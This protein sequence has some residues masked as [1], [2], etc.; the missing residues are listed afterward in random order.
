VVTNV[1]DD[2]MT[3][4]PPENVMV[5]LDEQNLTYACR[6]YSE[7]VG[8]KFWYEDSQLVTMLSKL[9]PNRRIAQVRCY[10]ALAAVDT[11][12]PNDEFRYQSQLNHFLDLQTNRKWYVFW[13]EVKSYDQ[14]CP[15]CRKK[16]GKSVPLICKTCNSQVRIPKN[17]GVDVALATDL[18]FY[19]LHY[20]FPYD[21]ATIVSGDSDFLPVVDRLK[22]ERPSVRIEFVQ[23]KRSVGDKIKQSPNAS[24]YDL[25]SRTNLFGHF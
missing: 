20:K 22:Q 25:D 9:R 23:F 18:L 5:F 3:I 14:M 1:C 10:S 4:S 6:D 15:N 12:R 21:T 7:Q 13:K 8:K 16:I 19:G 24:F 2:F 17:K 11:S